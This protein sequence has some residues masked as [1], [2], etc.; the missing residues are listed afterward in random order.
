MFS[1]TASGSFFQ[2]V[3]RDPSVSVVPPS[4]SYAFVNLIPAKD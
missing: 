4:I 1:F 3:L 2:D